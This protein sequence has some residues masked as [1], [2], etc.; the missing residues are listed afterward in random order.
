MMLK[1]RIL[2]RGEIKLPG[3][4]WKYSNETEWKPCVILNVEYQQLDPSVTVRRLDAWS[5][6]LEYV[7]TRWVYWPHPS[8][9]PNAAA[10]RL[11]LGTNQPK[12]P[13]EAS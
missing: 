9:Y 13:V 1:Y 4:E 8:D 7:A 3:D 6:A 5:T 11:A 12:R 2:K 10:R